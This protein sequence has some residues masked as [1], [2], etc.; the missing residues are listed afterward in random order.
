MKKKHISG[1]GVLFLGVVMGILF[2][3]VASAAL[4]F[5]GAA[6]SVTFTHDVL[7]DGTV[8]RTETISGSTIPF[9]PGLTFP[10]S[11]TSLTAPLT[12]DVD[13]RARAGFGQLTSPFFGTGTVKSGTLVTQ[14][15]LGNA[16]EAFSTLTIDFD[17]HWDAT[18][19]SFGPPII[20]RFNI[21]ILAVVGAGGEAKAEIIDMHWERSI[22]GTGTPT[23]LRAPVNV[24]QSFG[25]GTTLS[26]L[27]APGAAFSPFL[28]PAGD[29]LIVRGTV[30][31]STKNANE[32]VNF[33]FELPEYD[34]LILDADPV[35]YYRFD[36][37]LI[38]DNPDSLGLDVDDIAPKGGFNNGIFIDSVLLVTGI[39]NDPAN[40][41]IAFDSTDGFQV[42]IEGFQSFSAEAWIA[43]DE[44]GI[45]DSNGEA[46]G[47][48]AFSSTGDDD[49]FSVRTIDGTTDLQ[50]FINDSSGVKNLLGT[51]TMT[52][53]N[54]F[55]H[56]L[57]TWDDATKTGSFYLDGIQ[58]LNQVFP[59]LNRS[60]NLFNLSFGRLNYFGRVDEFAYYDYAL[61]PETVEARHLLGQT[62]PSQFGRLIGAEVSGIDAAIPEPMAGVL[63]LM[64]LSTLAMRRRRASV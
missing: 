19:P 50:V 8:M 58:V 39:D 40:P 3:N 54:D 6:S 13:S 60:G 44:P 10:L 32:P 63:C 21:P 25:P 36:D 4:V 20:G 11:D 43:S 7:D 46:F 17:L 5:D 51:V 15:D 16:T 12:T 33:Y 35:I 49:G 42:E 24:S 14:T 2:A 31:L 23:D 62:D 56:V 41:A 53:V 1:V 37:A 47:D 57:L 27:S 30:K 45:W 9:G 52:D 28:V 59:G 18:A 64:G 48:D 55:H 22:G 61:R 38:G 26:A 34:S 29:E